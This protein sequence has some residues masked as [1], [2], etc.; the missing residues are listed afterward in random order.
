M[1]QIILSLL[2]AIS[3]IHLYS[4]DAMPD[5]TEFLDLICIDCDLSAKISLK[6]VLD[7]TTENL[8]L[9]LEIEGAYDEIKWEGRSPLPVGLTGTV[10]SCSFLHLYC[11]FETLLEFR[12]LLCS[13][14]YR[15]YFI[16][17]AI[18]N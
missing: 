4:Q 17:Q 5:K 11:L 6:T 8:A 14:L 3:S 13:P 10:S 9:Q 2:L 1:R 18:I 16:V 15:F 7:C 12:R